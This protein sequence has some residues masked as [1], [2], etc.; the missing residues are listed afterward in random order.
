MSFRVVVEPRAEGDLQQ[1]YLYAARRA[2][3]GAARWLNR[4]QEA[5][6]SLSTLPERCPIA[7][8]S[9][10]VGIEV[11]QLL[12]GRKPNVWR[13]L[14]TIHDDEVRDLHIRRGSMQDASTS[15]LGQ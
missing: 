4:F 9:E 10:S 11:R 7:P 3:A 6:R 12:F 13:A 2:P 5:L 8:E 15:D 1:G 14:F